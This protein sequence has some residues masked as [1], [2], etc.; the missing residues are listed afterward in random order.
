M[1]LW[2]I[3]CSWR[4]QGRIICIC[5]PQVHLVQRKGIWNLTVK[6]K[7]G[8][9]KREPCWWKWIYIQKVIYN[10]KKKGK[11]Q[12]LWSLNIPSLSGWWLTDWECF[13]KYLCTFLLC[14]LFL[15]TFLLFVSGGSS[16]SHPYIY[17]SYHGAWELI[18]TLTKCFFLTPKPNH[19]TPTC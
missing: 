12:K 8:L 3:F 4:K 2:H 9:P 16:S 5:V 7:E 18:L 13:R 6:L 11:K 19:V 17:S 14:A 15:C 10:E 1:T